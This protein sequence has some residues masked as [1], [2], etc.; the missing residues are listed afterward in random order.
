MKKSVLLY[1]ICFLI[2]PFSLM[3]TDEII[4]ETNAE[5]FCAGNPSCQSDGYGGYT[6]SGYDSWFMLKGAVYVKSGY[7]ID[8]G[9]NILDENG[10]K[11]GF[12]DYDDPA[13]FIYR[14]TFLYYKTELENSKAR[15]TGI[16]YQIQILKSQLKV[17]SKAQNTELINSLV[18]QIEQKEL[19]LI[20][21]K[22]YSEDLRTFKKRDKF[23]LKKQQQQERKDLSIKLAE[24]RTNFS[25]QSK[26]IKASLKEQQANTKLSTAASY[27]PL[28]AD[29]KADYT[30]LRAQEKTT[31]DNYR[32]QISDKYL[33][34]DILKNQL[35]LGVISY[36]YYSSERIKTSSELDSL[37]TEQ[38][39]FKATMT[40]QKSQIKTEIEQLKIQKTVALG[41]LKINQKA[42]KESVYL[43]LKS[44]K[45]A[46]TQNHKDQRA[47]LT[48]TQ[49]NARENM[50]MSQ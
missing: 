35:A 48:T 13:N 15:I 11:V 28:I 43:N 17:A 36:E 31:N 5:S 8:D 34:L 44:Q 14:P 6:I 27:D 37:R 26:A 30:A 45:E 50:E 24:E 49:R 20:S 3:A 7:T 12:F 2:I 18:S 23:Y 4:T 25:I 33:R 16:K 10:N 40:V 39:N 41:T 32:A 29:K 21:E 47:Q 1:L 19:D 9:K 22:S 42:E 38:A 46:L